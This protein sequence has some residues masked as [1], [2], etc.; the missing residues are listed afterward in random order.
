MINQYGL[1]EKKPDDVSVGG[2]SL[3]DPGVLRLLLARM[4]SDD[5]IKLNDSLIILDCLCL[6][7]HDDKL[8]LFAC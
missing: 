2:Y 6:L 8:P 5:S 3:T 7:A 4:F 1:L